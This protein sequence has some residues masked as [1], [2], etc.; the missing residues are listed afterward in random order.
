MGPGSPVRVVV[1]SER[2][3]TLTWLAEAVPPRLG[4]RGVA[5]E[6]DTSPW[7]AFGGAVA[8]MH[9]DA[10][11]VDEQKK[12]ISDFGLRETRCACCSPVTSP[13]RASTCTSSATSSSTSTCPG[14]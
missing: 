12:I 2:I 5:D 8:V 14:R 13:P 9:G 6:D 11:T 7:M 10:N 1:F 4:F 3:P